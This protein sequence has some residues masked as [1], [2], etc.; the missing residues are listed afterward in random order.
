MPRRNAAT[1]PAGRDVRPGNTRRGRGNPHRSRDGFG[2]VVLAV[3][4]GCPVERYARQLLVGVGKRASGAVV[5]RAAVGVRTS[6]MRRAPRGTNIRGLS[7]R[8]TLAVPLL[9]CPT[10]ASPPLYVP[11]VSCR[12]R[13]GQ[14]QAGFCP[15]PCRSESAS[16]KGPESATGVD[17]DGR[18]RNARSVGE[19]Q[20]EPATHGAMPRTA[21]HCPQT[22]RVLR[23]LRCLRSLIPSRS[24]RRGS[25]PLAARPNASR[26]RSAI[27]GCGASA[28]SGPP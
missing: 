21:R 17:R 8:R 13:T 15:P 7:P 3:S 16:G 11:I 27:G 28:S 24:A 23:T 2:W 9:P 12:D 14:S 19:G 1:D 18:T 25:L 26:M 20:K 10:A 22:G 5:P 4:A 6:R